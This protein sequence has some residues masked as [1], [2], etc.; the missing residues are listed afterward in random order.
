MQGAQAAVF[1]I[2]A[3]KKTALTVKSLQE[4]HHRPT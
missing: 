4:Y 3:M 2:D 1:G